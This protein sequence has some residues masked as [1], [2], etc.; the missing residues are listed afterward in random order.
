M[1]TQALFTALCGLVAAQRLAELD[2][3]KQNEERLLARGGREHG[4]G[5]FAA[6]RA[7]HAGWL[8]SC[9]AEVWLLERPFTLEL[10]LPMLVLF[11]TGQC[12]RLSARRALSGRWSVR[13]I[14]LPGVPL[15]T[16]G[17]YRFL[18][19]PNYLGVVLELAAL[20]LVHG[21]W[22]TA[23]VFSL[24]N[25]LVLAVRIRHEEAALALDSG[26]LA[27]GGPR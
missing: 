3:S 24:L 6:M 16:S 17:P 8:V 10:A 11:A 1:V 9:C 25:A 18:R 20:P 15:V 26:L 14:T 13:V 27:Q 5:H 22:L 21:A 4:A 19:H 7:L 23:I 12:L 2:A